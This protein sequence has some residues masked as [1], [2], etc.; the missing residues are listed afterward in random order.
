MQNILWNVPNKWSRNID[1]FPESFPHWV[2]SNISK[3][4]AQL[5]NILE[6]FTGDL[7]E[8]EAYVE[9]KGYSYITTFDSDEKYWSYLK[10]HDE[11]FQNWEYI[12]GVFMES[13]HD[14]IVQ[15]KR[16]IIV[17]QNE[18][19]DVIQDTIHNLREEFNEAL[20]SEFP[21]L[22]I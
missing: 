8:L 6:Y 16:I 21:N 19:D 14:W 10:E 22:V 7:N 13:L 5:K 2:G 9:S 12:P 11:K 17:Q 1:M 20:Y 4:T 18:D 3:K 15:R